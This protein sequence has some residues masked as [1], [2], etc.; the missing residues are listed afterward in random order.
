MPAYIQ[1]VLDLI[2]YANGDARTTEWGRRR[3]EA[4]HPKP[5][6]LKY[7][8]IGNEDLITDIFAERFQMI[9]D[10]VRQ[11]YPEVTVI[12][13]VGPFWEGTDYEEGWQL[14]TRLGV[15][16]VDEHYYE[17]PG[18]FIHH[19]EYYDRYDRSKPRVYLGEYAAHLPDRSSCIETA[20]AEALYLTAVERN[21]DVVSM[22]SYAPLLAKKGH[23]Q[24]RPDL[25]YFDNHSVQ[26]TVDYYV[27]Q[28]YGQHAGTHYLPSTL[29]VE[30][31]RSD[32]RRRIGLSV[33]RDE[34]T[35]DYL[36]KMV[37]MLPVEVET[38]IDLSS[39][40]GLETQATCTVLSG[41]PADSQA[42]PVSNS[43]ETEQ[44]QNGYRQP[45]YS[46]SVIRLKSVGEK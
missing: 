42:I 16:I 30:T 6:N 38:K 40:G 46:F 9:F 17:T 43:I 12:G 31:S 21:A 18:W 39:L 10:A 20:L 29:K 27:Q 4:G 1:D 5:F 37:N 22:T 26:P 33:T 32:V 25:I 14:A 35:G 3:A 7:I 36:L 11:H 13:T 44:L 24:W 34:A 15:P 41:Q 2:E 19:Q 45:A 28:L 23:T 8:G